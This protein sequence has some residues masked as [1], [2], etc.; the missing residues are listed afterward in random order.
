MKKLTALILFML[1]ML[2]TIAGAAIPDLPGSPEVQNSDDLTHAAMT[3]LLGS[4]WSIIAGASSAA[5]SGWA[6]FGEIIV[7]LLGFI[8]SAAMLF[9]GAS[10]FYQAG[11]FGLTTAHEGKKLGG[12]VFNSLWVPIRWVTGISFTVPV[13]NGLSLLQVAMMGIL[14][15]S[16]NMA[17]FAWDGVGNAIVQASSAHVSTA[18]P[19]TTKESGEKIMPALVRSAAIQIVA[20]VRA[21]G[22]ANYTPQSTSGAAIEGDGYTITLDYD[23]GKAIFSADVPDG[24]YS[25]QMARVT[26]D[27]PKSQQGQT[28]AGKIAL[29]KQRYVMSQV[30]AIAQLWTSAKEYARYYLAQQGITGRNVPNPGSAKGVIDAYAASVAARSQGL[31]KIVEDVYGDEYF[32]RSLGMSEGKSKNGWATAGLHTFAIAS[33]QSTANESLKTRVT[34]Q[35][36]SSITYSTTANDVMLHFAVDPAEAM[37]MSRIA[38]QASAVSTYIGP[39]AARVIDGIEQWFAKQSLGQAAGVAAESEDTVSGWIARNLGI[40]HPDYRGGKSLLALTVN[41]LEK[42]NPL[43]LLV[44][45][46]DTLLSLGAGFFGLDLAI[47]WIPIAGN[48]TQNTLSQAALM[49]CIVCGVFLFYVFPFV[50]FFIWSWALL[51]WVLLVIKSMI[52]APF[53]AISHIAPAGHGFAGNQARKGYIMFLDIFARPTL[54]VCGAVVAIMITRY[55]GFLIGQLA[56]VA[57][58][59]DAGQVGVIKD[60]IVTAVLMLL[61]VTLSIYC[62]RVCVIDIPRKIIEWL[63]GIGS[64]L[65][66]EKSNEQTVIMGAVNR[67]GAAL[68][69]ATSAGAKAITD[70]RQLLKNKFGKGKGGGGGEQGQIASSNPNPKPGPGSGGGGNPAPKTGGNDLG[71][72]AKA[73]NNAPSN[74]PATDAG[75]ENNNNTIG[76]IAPERS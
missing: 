8:N 52:A 22:R 34:V 57:F 35:P 39:E 51:G 36:G 72:I 54:M 48:L 31:T 14:G 65:G 40:V 63:G 44:D 55:V 13:L 5:Q 46:G 33:A 1:L 50:P 12:S 15:L 71:S 23:N 60:L 59:G 27:L 4:A 37:A 49:G 6:A 43:I 3:G 61:L 18:L 28:D 11:I 16:I 25:Q 73:L 32:G 45:F 19:E 53:W 66:E 75:P 2:P 42:E 29:E 24:L 17:N 26:F 56:L 64:T 74:A 30:S 47:G 38:G 58:A 10:I 62:F 20:D 7:T 67:G 70:A 68:P 41:K 9:V 76:Q 21:G 69:G